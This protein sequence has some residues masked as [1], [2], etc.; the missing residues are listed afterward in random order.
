MQSRF[1]VLGTGGT[2]AGT[3]ASSSDVLG[4]TAAQLGIGELLAGVPGL[5]Q[6]PVEAEQVAQIDSKDATHALWQALVQRAS[7]HLQRPEVAGVVVTHGTDTMEESAYVMHRV[8]AP[9]DKPVVLVGAMRP[10]TALAADGPQNLVD[11]FTLASLPGAR[12][13]LVALAGEVHA[14]A[15]VRKRHSHRL[16]AFSSG[17]A[18]PLALIEAGRVRQLREWPQGEALGP[19]LLDMP[20]ERWPRVDIVLS[21][22]GADG[23][24]VRALCAAGVDGL[25]VA[26]TGNG[27]L[28]DALAESL[29]EARAQGVRVRVASRCAEGGVIARAQERFDGAGLLTPVA[30]RAELLLQLLAERRAAGA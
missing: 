10:A 21:H 22:A 12:G 11:A 13:V 1:V 27:S 9:R 3:A 4:Y 26:G 23:R 2:I 14:G 17:D 25:V 6:L 15:E 19:A 24:V 8:L 7:H 30:A 16:D 20:V 18:G 29:D 28:H 5:R